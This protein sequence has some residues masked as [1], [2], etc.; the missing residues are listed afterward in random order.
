MIEQRV[1]LLSCFVLL[2]F[3]HRLWVFI[4]P[5]DFF[6]VKEYMKGPS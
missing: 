2:I 5:T 3:S 6:K 4:R 1:H